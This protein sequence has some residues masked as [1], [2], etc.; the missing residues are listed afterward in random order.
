M[1]TQK[2]DARMYLTACDGLGVAPERCLYVGD[3]N[4]N[5]LTGATAVGLRAVYL[6]AE[7]PLRPAADYEGASWTGE[8]VTSLAEIPPLLGH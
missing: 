8:R 5:E 2:P 3:G 1:G 6:D 7:R 4:S